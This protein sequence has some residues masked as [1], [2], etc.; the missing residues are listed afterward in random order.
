MAA[1]TL[2]QIDLF[3]GISAE[4]M[5]WLLTNSRLLHLRNGEYFIKEGDPDVKFAVVLEGEMQVTRQIQGATTVLG[6]T[7]R[8]VCCGQLNLLNGTPAEQT[9]QAIMS[10]TLLVFE[11]DA[12]RGI[13]GACPRVGSRILRIAAERMAMFAS[14]ETQQQK[15]AALGKLSAGLAHE[16][17][18]PAAAARRSA[19]LLQ[20]ALPALQIQTMTLNNYGFT[21]EQ[22]EM[23]KSLQQGLMSPLRYHSALSPLE[24]S[25]L[26]EGMG[27]WLEEHEVANGWKIAAVL[28]NAGISVDDLAIMY[29]QVGADAV[30][31][32]IT[33]MSHLVMAAE[34]LD[35]V[36]Q[37]SKRISDLV[38]AIKEYTYV[39]RAP[40]SDDV[41]LERGL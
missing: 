20:E 29:D 2:Y 36:A 31:A 23:L 8:G 13:F 6:T 22:M 24:R 1:D 40:M 21:R 38:G 12:F 34:L 25:D 7:P 41:D 3:E 16:L 11:P 19:Q 5:N 30:P 28:V 15:M 9:I 32:V 18:N 14:Q 26:E 35:D 17:N 27:S 37:S 10:C 33:W 4:E 39:D